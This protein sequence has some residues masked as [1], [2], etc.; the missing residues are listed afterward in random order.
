M[1]QPRR[2]R[3]RNG[4]PWEAVIYT[5]EA[6]G[7]LWT[8]EAACQDDWVLSSDYGS[9][10]QAIKALVAAMDTAPSPPRTLRV[11]DEG[12]A[13]LLG[14]Y[15]PPDVR[16]VMVD[17]LDM[18]ERLYDEETAEPEDMSSI[19]AGIPAQERGAWAKLLADLGPAGLAGL[20]PAELT[21]EAPDGSVAFAVVN[22]DGSPSLA[23]AFDEHPHPVVV[24][25]PP[26]SE[27]GPESAESLRAD[28][29][30]RVEH[31]VE[32]RL[33]VFVEADD[34]ARPAEAVERARALTTFRRIL[35]ATAG[36]TLV[37]GEVLELAEDTG[38]TRITVGAVDVLTHTVL[39]WVPRSGDEAADTLRIEV[40]GEL[41]VGLVAALEDVVRLEHSVCV[42]CGKTNVAAV[43]AAGT[44]VNLHHGAQALPAE[45]TQVRLQ[46][47]GDALLLDQ[48]LPLVPA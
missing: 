15:L 9:Q 2:S 17:S 8:C 14:R 35:S 39:T 20:P 21:V 18:I 31:G 28:G 43:L 19:P 12:L 1:A 32:A 41:A 13:K 5:S 26:L 24:G 27:G 46:V 25:L 11:V 33:A 36:R 47:W 42:G 4:P 38:T 45:D 40:P 48:T 16:A 7:G 30:V 23:L 44:P 3:P 37:P 22:G 6:H 34:G 10:T 29:L